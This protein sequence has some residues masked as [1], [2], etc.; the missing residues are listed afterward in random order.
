MYKL[1]ER[2]QFDWYVMNS[3]VTRQ[4]TQIGDET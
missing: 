2:F 1:T 4:L 3:W